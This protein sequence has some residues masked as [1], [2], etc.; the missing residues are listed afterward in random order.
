MKTLARNKRAAFDYDISTTWQAGIVLTGQEVKACKLDHCSITEAIIDVNTQNWE[1]T[2]KGMNIPLYSKANPAQIW[3][4]DPKHP[5]KLLLNRR[6]ITKIAAKISQ[7]WWVTLIPL[8]LVE[9]HN[10]RIKLI[11]WL[12]KR[13]RKVEKRQLIKERDTSREMQ[14]E[15]NRL[16]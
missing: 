5:R 13:R 14:K 15:I 12:A 4:Y 16:S 11:V 7:W 6:E 3:A 8:E 1:V 2:I 9:L 10:R